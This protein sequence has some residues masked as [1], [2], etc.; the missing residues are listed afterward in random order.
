MQAN[1]EESTGIPSIHTEIN[2]KTGQQSRIYMITQAF[3][4]AFKQMHHYFKKFTRITGKLTRI[5]AQITS[6]L[7]LQGQNN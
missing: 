4:P 1:K 6:Y 3:S 5:Q 2:N 7:P